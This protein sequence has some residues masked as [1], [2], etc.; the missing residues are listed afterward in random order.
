[1]HQNMLRDIQLESSLTEEVLEVLV[2]IKW[3]MS[4]QCTAKKANSI[5]GCIRKNAASRLR[6]SFKPHLV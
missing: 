6:P 4:Q 2:D 3:N 5:L 1:M